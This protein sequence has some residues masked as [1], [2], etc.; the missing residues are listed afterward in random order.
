MVAL[1][2]GKLDYVIC[3]MATAA[4]FAK[5]NS[6][7]VYVDYPLTEEGL[8]VAVAKGN[9]QLQE[10]IS[11]CIQSYRENGVLED[12]KKRWYEASGDG[13]ETVD[14]PVHEDGTVM[15]VV[16]TGSQE[17]GPSG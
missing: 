1:Q 13:Y 8:A 11:A 4:N 9:T 5:A 3:G 6:D 10:G 16:V 2:S 14:I 17:T 12:M 15:R 7:V